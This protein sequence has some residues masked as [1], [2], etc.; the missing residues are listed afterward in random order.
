VR[1]IS[2]HR[3]RWG[4]EPICKTL[5]VAPSTYYAAVS[6]QPSTRQLSD[7]LLKPEIARVHRNNFGVY[8]IQKVWRQLNRE[9][10]RV[11]RDRVG[12]LMDDLA[13]QRR[14]ARQT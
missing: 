4:I 6:H 14:R 11:G 8:G 2:A 3:E 5:Q 9:G 12:R 1:F 7:E 13:A 10:H